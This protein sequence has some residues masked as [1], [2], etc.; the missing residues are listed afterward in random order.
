MKESIGLKGIEEMRGKIGIDLFTDLAEKVSASMANNEAT[1]DVPI[2][3]KDSIQGMTSS[4]AE[5]SIPIGDG[6]GLEKEKKAKS[7]G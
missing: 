3:A 1:Q 6:K 2:S 5:A 4:P 7:E